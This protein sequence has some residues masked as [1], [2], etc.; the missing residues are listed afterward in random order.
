MLSNGLQGSLLSV[1]ALIEDFDV[2]ITGVIMS[3]YYVGIISGSLIVPKLVGKVGHIRSF[4]ALAS[5]ASTSILIHFIFIN[6]SIWWLMRFVTGFAYAGL[7]IVAESWLNDEAENNT[8]GQLLSFY[9]LIQLGGLA[10]GQLLLNMA[11][12]SDYHLFV[13]ISIMVSVAVIPI[14]VTVSKAPAY[15][16]REAVSIVYLFKVSPLGLYGIMVSGLCAGSLLGIGPIYGTKIGLSIREISFFMVSMIIGGFILQ[17]PIG[18]LSDK[19][20]RRQIIIGIS[21]IGSIICFSASTLNLIDWQLYSG[22]ALIGGLS[23]PLYSLC[24]AYTNDYLTQSQMVAA[25]GGLVLANGIGASFGAP[26]TAY[27]IDLLGPSGFFQI[28]ALVLGS[29]GIFALWRATQ[30]E[31]ISGETVGDFTI[32]APTPIGASL[33]PE[34]NLKE[35]EAAGNIDIVEI[36]ASLKDLVEG[37]NEKA[38]N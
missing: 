15:E 13:L 22:I 34:L 32:I 26:V 30:R 27:A 24:V 29:I 12:P 5:L 23:F 10:G 17:Y 3:G 16:A 37:L 1:R 14:L 25:S 20:G 19:R 21:A 9:M 18:M 38:Q 4:G 2:S 36:E 33:N 11:N 28:N 8:R 31:A 6:P 35:I 7:Y